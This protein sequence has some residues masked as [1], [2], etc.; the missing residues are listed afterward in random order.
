M[1]EKKRKIYN[2]DEDYER[3]TTLARLNTKHGT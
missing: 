2:F 3:K 1:R